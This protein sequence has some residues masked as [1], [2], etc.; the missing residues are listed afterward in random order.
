MHNMGAPYQ[1]QGF[2]SQQFGTMQQG[3]QQPVHGFVYVQGLEAARAYPLPN[4]SE[5]PLFDNDSDLLYIKVV[6]QAGRA[7]VKVKKCIDYVEQSHEDSN[8]A[9]QDDIRAVYKEIEELRGA[10]GAIHVQPAHAKE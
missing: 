4:G 7:S 6:D 5:M 10:I 2:Q 1:Q 9:T 3:M 8:Y